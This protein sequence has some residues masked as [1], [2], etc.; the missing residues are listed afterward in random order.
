M[1]QSNPSEKFMSLEPHAVAHVVLKASCHSEQHRN[2][3]APYSS[4]EEQP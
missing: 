3:A 1:G 2:A 4:S